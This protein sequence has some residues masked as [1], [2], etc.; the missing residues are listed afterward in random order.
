MSNK[1]SKEILAKEIESKLNEGHNFVDYFLT[2]GSNP[3]IFK[4]NWLYESDISTLN[5]KYQESIKPIM[6]NR[7]P[8]KDKA[9]LGFDDGIIYHCFPEGFKVYEFNKQPEYKIFSILLDNNNY[10]INY[11]FKYIVC[12]KFYESISSYKKLYD[13]YMEVKEVQIPK[14]SDIN[15]N[16]NDNDIFSEENM[17]S[18]K[19]MNISFKKLRKTSYISQNDYF[20]NNDDIY[21]PEPLDGDCISDYNS[22]EVKYNFKEAQY[23]FEKGNNNDSKK[24]KIEKH[25]YKKYYIPKCIC[26]ISLYPFITEM[27]KII[28]QIY[29]YSLVEKQTY[30]L[31][32]II[33]NLLIDVPVP[34]KGIY[35]IEYTLFNQNIILKATQKNDF[36][37][38]NI[39]FQ[40]LFTLLKIN[41]IIDIFRHLMLNTKIII[42][43]EEIRNLTPIMLTL[44]SLLYPFQYPYNTVSILHKDAYKF[45]EHIAPVFVGINEK[46][47]PNF[48]EENDLEIIDYILIVNI[49][50]RELIKLEPESQK[51]KIFLPQLPQK[52]KED[53]ENKINNYYHK[54]TLNKKKNGKGETA[55][56][57]QQTICTFFLEF[58][59]DLMKDYTKYLNND[60]YKYQNDNRNF[61]EN[62]FKLKEFINKIPYEYQQFYECFLKTQ[63]F[64][65]F[66]EKRMTP[67]NK[68]AQIDFLFFE[69]IMLK[70]KT[71]SILLT[72]Q[73]YNITKP[74]I[75][76]KPP[77]LSSQQISYFNNIDNKNKL[78]LNGIELTNK[79]DYL[80]RGY[81][82]S[83]EN[84]KFMN[85]H[86]NNT[87]SKSIIEELDMENESIELDDDRNYANYYNTISN[88][89]KSMSFK[90]KNSNKLKTKEQRIAS[91]KNYNKMQPLFSYIIFPKLDCKY[92]FNSDIYNYRID[93]S[94]YQE[95]KNIDNE[96]ISKSHLRRVEIKTN[97]TT[98][99]IHLLWLKLWVSSFYYHDKQEQK[100]RFFQMLKIIERISQHEMGVI[101]NLFNVLIDCKIDEDLILLL[102]E[103]ILHYKLIPSDFIFTKIGILMSKKKKSNP[104]MKTFN[105]S[106]YIK[107]LKKTI[108]KEFKESIIQRK[109][110]RKRTLK[111]IYDTQILDEKVIFLMDE[112][113]EKCDKKI[114]MNQF[115]L[116]IINEVDDDLCWAK[117]PYCR[118]NY[119]P[120]LKIIYGNENNKNNK[121]I[122][123]TSIV[124]NVMLY[125]PKTLNVHMYENANNKNNTMN[126]DELKVNYNPLFWNAIWY[127]KINKLPFDFILP[128]EDNIFHKLIKNIKINEKKE[129]NIS[130]NFNLTLSD[131]IEKEKVKLEYKR[132][133]WNCNTELI[134]LSH[135]INIYIPPM[136]SFNKYNYLKTN[137]SN[138]SNI[139]TA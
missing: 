81:S 93:Y 103:K 110:F 22:T 31:E 127:F 100:Y 91:K 65:E 77:P 117:C 85:I 70:N 53:L 75:V 78:L 113:C 3:S 28:K 29:Q 52:Y 122:S 32:K 119:L 54:I 18:S 138:Y 34:P 33:N 111:S 101:N 126:I 136:Y 121:L 130:D 25:K 129:K 20:N 84:T 24:K 76:P 139:T 47:T 82:F 17:N 115:M 6:I 26:L 8:S 49:D 21:Y 63:T 88:P 14:D 62:A 132:K 90:V 67:K 58:Q 137:S 106:K 60:M 135:E 105:I 27:S 79:K 10:S 133:F 4:N 72:T 80:N 71:E 120:K 30:P 64:T 68:D 95:I 83:I 116:N 5:T 134:I 42:F 36:H 1:K 38:L 125:S 48:F 94:M 23:F 109:K 66:L 12:L 61:E 104:N 86:N 89:R 99:Y 57:F 128:Y 19:S 59:I 74:I 92:F 45:I 55:K 13:K 73:N 124:D 40:K 102:Y 46:Y 11:P 98:N 123:T 43:S 114:E 118:N 39:E 96:I 131:Y 7:F 51:N 41:I 44:L 15:N 2:I 16:I 112:N 9:I 35:Y 97:E 108:N 56:K 87:S 37:V 107:S 50:K 69:E